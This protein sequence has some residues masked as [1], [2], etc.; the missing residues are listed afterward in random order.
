LLHR[1]NNPTNLGAI[2]RT[3]EAVKRRGRYFDK[4]LGDVFSPK[5][6]RGAW[7][8]VCACPIWTNADFDEVLNWAKDKNLISVC[9]DVNAKKSYLEIEW[10]TPRLLIFG[11]EAHGF[12]R[13]TK[14]KPSTKI[15]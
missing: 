11:S 15:Y 13:R 3:C 12:E 2:L 4:K 5:A 1:I 10:K 8:Q 14:E 6:L 9:A 7:A